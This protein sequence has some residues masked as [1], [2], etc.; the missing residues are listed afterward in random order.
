MDVFILS[1]IASGDRCA[2]AICDNVSIAERVLPCPKSVA[3]ADL[4][5]ATRLAWVPQDACDH[6]RADAGH[7][8]PGRE[9]PHDRTS[10]DRRGPT[11][12]FSLVGMTAAEQ[13]GAEDAVEK[14]LSGIKGI[15]SWRTNPSTA[16]RFLERFQWFADG[17][18]AGAGRGCL[19]SSAMPAIPFSPHRFEPVR[20]MPLCTRL[21]PPVQW[22]DHARGRRVEPSGCGSTRCEAVTRALRA[23]PPNAESTR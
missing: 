3:Q 22:V 7:C 14:R 12:R 21:E 13:H 10:G 1:T 23:L 16:A 11:D 5:H 8:R 20:G 17:W 2:A 18:V 4:L 9:R 15:R 19:R 6:T